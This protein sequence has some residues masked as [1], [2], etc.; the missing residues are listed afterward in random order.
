MCPQVQHLTS[1]TSQQTGSRLLA[2]YEYEH[3]RAQADTLEDMAA[4]HHSEYL[5]NAAC[6]AGEDG[7]FGF[8]YDAGS[9]IMSMVLHDVRGAGKADKTERLRERW[10][11]SLLHVA[12]PTSA[13]QHLPYLKRNLHR[14]SPSLQPP[15][16]AA[17][18]KKG[19]KR[20]AKGAAPE[21]AGGGARDG[22]G[23]AD[24]G[25][26]PLVWS[27][28]QITNVLD[29]KGNK[30]RMG[31]TAFTT[32]VLFRREQRRSKGGYAG[33]ARGPRVLTWQEARLEQIPAEAEAERVRR[34]AEEE[35]EARARKE[36]ESEEEGSA[37]ED[38]DEEREQQQE[39]PGD[40]E[41]KME[42][43]DAEVQDDEG[44]VDASAGLDTLMAVSLDE[45]DAEG[46]SDKLGE[47][48]ADRADMPEDAPAKKEPR[49]K[50]A[51][52]KER[53]NNDED[54]AGK[55]AAAGRRSSRRR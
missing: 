7:C 10:L 8:Y 43:D 16:G 51:A 28:L 9:G 46:E 6:L 55:A 1:E 29:G 14:P 37:D 30:V 31:F 25:R 34:A 18:H 54:A 3:V 48:A 26:E 35:E 41:D 50:A 13:P 24:S 21:A 12:A 39:Q 47:D 38:E 22:A 40:G 52:A 53:D 32:D 2:L 4:A 49:P 19:G 44:A 42:E 23:G 15:A 33:E 27:D 20:G 45:G 5:R 17:A 36:A 11:D